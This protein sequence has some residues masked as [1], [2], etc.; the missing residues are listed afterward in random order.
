M[1]SLHARRE[2]LAPSLVARQAAFDG[3]T[4]GFSNYL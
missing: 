4:Q 2:P 1:G 3:D